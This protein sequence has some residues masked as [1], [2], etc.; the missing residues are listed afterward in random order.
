MSASY[1]RSIPLVIQSDTDSAPKELEDEVEQCLSAIIAPK[2][3]HNARVA[4]SRLPNELLSEIFTCLVRDHNSHIEDAHDTYDRVY[5]TRLQWIRTTHVCY[6]WREV[7]LATPRLW[8]FISV[9][10]RAAV[11]AGPSLYLYGVSLVP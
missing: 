11:E 10:R 5:G 7:A 4:I 8:S 2:R 9:T 6:A 1:T 3:C